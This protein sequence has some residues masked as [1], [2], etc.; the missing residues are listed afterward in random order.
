MFKEKKN[1]ISFIFCFIL[2]YCIV[3]YSKFNEFALEFKE[4]TNSTARIIKIDSDDDW[5]S[6]QYSVGGKIYT[7]SGGYN[8]PAN[9]NDIINIVYVKDHPKISSDNS[10]SYSFN[11][12]IRE[13]IP[14]FLFSLIIFG[15]FGFSLIRIGNKIWKFL[16]TR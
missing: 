16:F 14:A 4:T 9:I 13:F 15:F 6:Y 1:L 3:I 8:T 5:Y 12:F 7:G 11:F 10:D 2:S